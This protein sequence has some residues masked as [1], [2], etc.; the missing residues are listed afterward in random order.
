[1]GAGFCDRLAPQK[2]EKMPKLRTKA[3]NHRRP[4]HASQRVT[5]VTQFLATPYDCTP[6]YRNSWQAL[7]NLSHRLA[8]VT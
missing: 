8:V 5:T 2:Q 4:L 1:M 3:R 7:L 6:N